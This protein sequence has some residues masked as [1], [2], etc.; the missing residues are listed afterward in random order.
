MSSR[1]GL[2]VRAIR[3]ALVIGAAG[4][5]SPA[6]GLECG[7]ARTP[8][9]TAICGDPAVKEADDAVSA[10]FA[11]LRATLPAAD[12]KALLANQR[13]WLKTREAR[14]GS[15]AP[16]AT[17]LRDRTV[18]RARVLEG[19]PEAGPGTRR[20][21]LPL[22]VD[23]PGSK[24][25]YAVSVFLF[26]F[27][28]PASAAEAALNRRVAR[29]A[30]EAPTATDD[31]AAATIYEWERKARLAY[32][33]DRLLSIGVDGYEMTGGAHGNSSF[34]AINLDMT[35]GRELTVADLTDEAGRARL[36]ALCD[37]QVRTQLRDKLKESGEDPDTPDGKASL[38]ALE[39][40]AAKG[41]AE[42]V[43]DLSNWTFGGTGATVT[44]LPYAVAPYVYGAFSCEI[45]YANLRPL[46][47]ASFPM[48]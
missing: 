28:K 38:A 39:G 7:G 5:V 19:T 46:A 43:G 42:T 8:V 17:C 41:V 12:A 14:C 15:P 10:A 36:A 18:A 35:T 27:P 48:P 26:R 22:I 34:G 24:S 33:S 9:E 44:F 31:P 30:A 2:A 45:P 13:N 20:P 1:A 40:D 3:A 29:I 32:A 23:R 6:F 4:L 21:L 16:N 47:K 25:R 11:R 37:G